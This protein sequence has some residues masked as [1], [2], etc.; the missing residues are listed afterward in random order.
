MAIIQ[1]HGSS[2]MH[3]TMQIRH[4]IKHE[5]GGGGGGGGLTSSVSLMDGAPKCV[6]ECDDTHV[7]P[8]PL[9]PLSVSLCLS[10]GRAEQLNMA[11][12][13]ACMQAC[14]DVISTPPI[15]LLCH[16]AMSAG[17]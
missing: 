15:K 4:S 8:K 13:D 12:I 16:S 11:G 3:E 14:D 1:S 17:S 9:R 7:P 10:L 6:R 5:N 2:T